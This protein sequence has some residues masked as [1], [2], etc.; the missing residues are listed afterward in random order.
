MLYP[1]IKSYVDQ[2]VADMG[3][4]SDERKKTLSQLSDYITQRYREGATPSV[5]VICTHNSRR[6]HMGQLWLAIGAEYYSLPAI[7]TYSGGTEATA[8]N[9]RA[10]AAFE[11]IGLNIDIDGGSEANPHYRIRWSDDM[12]S[13]VAYSKKYGDP[14]NPQQ[15]Y[16]AVM[17]CTSADAGCPIVFG[18]SVRVSIPYEDPKAYDDTDLEG[19]MY[20]ERAQQIGTEMLYVMSEVKAAL[21]E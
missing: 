4:I 21:G 2:L 6:S 13:Y 3:D 19:A 18:S 20:D 5:T 14:P 15:D 16:A 17:V 1:A 8:F 11:R 10:V 9:P 7:E 12:T